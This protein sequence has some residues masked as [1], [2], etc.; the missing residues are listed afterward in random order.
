MKSY[1]TGHDHWQRGRRAEARAAFTAAR[2]AIDE[3][4]PSANRNP[5]TL[6]M[7]GRIELY[8]C[9][10]LGVERDAESLAAGRRAES[11]FRARP[12]ASR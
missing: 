3:A 4:S 9:R 5:L 6:A 7:A 8:L 11:L 2:A 1:N 10:A 12:R